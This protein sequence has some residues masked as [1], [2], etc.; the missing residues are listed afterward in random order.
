MV[1]I[2]FLNAFSPAVKKLGQ[3]YPAIYSLVMCLQFI[4]FVGIW[5]MKRWGLELFILSFFGK[6]VLLLC[7]NDFS[8]GSFTFILSGLFIIILIFFYRRMDMNL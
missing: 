8:Y 2:S 3:F 7:M 5:Y 6:A 4:A 1:V